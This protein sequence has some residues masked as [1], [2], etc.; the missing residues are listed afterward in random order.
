MNQCYKAI[1]LPLLIGMVGLV[2]DGGLLLSCHER[3]QN[4]A[5]ATARSVVNRMKNVMSA[6]HSG[7]GA[8]SMPSRRISLKY[9]AYTTPALN[10]SCMFNAP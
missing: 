3:A 10:K 5:D 2:V 9:A 4:I 1:L 6:I 8:F 7:D